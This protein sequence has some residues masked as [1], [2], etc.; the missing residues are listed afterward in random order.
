MLH[1]IQKIVVAAQA[2]EVCT[3]RRFCTR[4]RRFLGLR[5]RRIRKVDTVF[6][7]VPFR[8]APIVCC[9]CE[10]PLQVEYPYSPMTEFV[11]ERATTELHTVA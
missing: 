1:S 2:E 5:D 7:T 6:V 8:S 3:L 4:C 9:P 11:P 10:T